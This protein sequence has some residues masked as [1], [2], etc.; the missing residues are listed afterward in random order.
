MKNF[1][2]SLI[3]IL[4]FTGMALAE[5]LPVKKQNDTVDPCYKYGFSLQEEKEIGLKAAEFLIKKYGYYDN[6]KVNS[7]V[8]KV[9]LNIVSKVSK[10]KIDYTFYTLDSNEI[11]SFALPGGFIFITKGTLSYIS[12]EAELA[13]ILSHEIAHIEKCD[14][15]KTLR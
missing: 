7:Y 4:T 14:C 9:G 5:A 13:G 15:L 2:I 11:N 1:L 10:R 3:L 12:N 8:T 6:D